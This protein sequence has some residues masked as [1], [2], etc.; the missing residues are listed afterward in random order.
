MMR[1]GFIGLGFLGSAMA[2]RLMGEGVSLA[3][4]NRTMAKAEGLGCPVAKDPAALAAAEEVI[5]LNLFDSRAVSDVLRGP[6]GLLSANLEGKT[7]IDTT[8]NHCEEV[9]EFHRVLAEKGAA[10]VEAPV[11]GSVV[12]ASQG[13]LTV[14]VSG[15]EKGYER[16]R[17]YL[18]KVGS[19]I[20]FLGGEGL[21][22]RMKLVNNLLL[23]TFMAAIGEAVS[24]GESAGVG[25]EK[26]LDILA[27]GAGNSG[28]L[29]AK[30]E[31]LLK[32]DFS[33]H[34]SAAL[35]Y[36]D[37]HYLQDLA[38]SLKRP[39]ITGSMVKELF[40]LTRSQGIDNL[41]FSVVYK[42]LKGL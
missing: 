8:S 25:K 14:L 34:F 27:A 21:A 35:I 5:F 42:V 30:R 7:V 10:Y 41:D 24:L 11:L 29:N 26:V 19:K 15:T 13:N 12:P 38:R 33:T 9:L 20:F 17:P 22:S 31:K 16:A 39:L 32:E 1:A 6:G 23:G 2:K 28:V 37:L 40:A 4:W 3:V 36:K 18:E